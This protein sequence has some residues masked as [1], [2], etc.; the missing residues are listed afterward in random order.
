MNGEGM[1]WF[2]AR[3]FIDAGWAVRRDIWNNTTGSLSEPDILHWILFHNNLFYVCESD[4]A[5]GSSFRVVT[6][7]DFGTDEFNAKDWTV[8][9][10]DCYIQSADVNS[11]FEEFTSAL[12]M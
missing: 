11:A 7:E 5:G 4:G 10:V 2:Q 9:P 8:H 12:W 3:L 6:S 1:N